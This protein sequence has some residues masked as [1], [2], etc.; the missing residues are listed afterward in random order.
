MPNEEINTTTP[1]TDTQYQL[2][3]ITFESTATAD[4]TTSN[5]KEIDFPKSRTIKFSNSKE[6]VS[7]SVDYARVEIQMKNFNSN[8]P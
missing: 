5:F 7:F 1:I 6:V 3:E 4:V 8:T 2:S